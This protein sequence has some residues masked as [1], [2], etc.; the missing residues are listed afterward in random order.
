ML[1]P[2][3]KLIIIAMFFNFLLKPLFAEE[4]LKVGI[5]SLP[6]SRGNPYKTTTGLPSL[7]THAALFEGLTRV[8]QKA[9]PIPILAERWEYENQFSWL[10]FLRKDVYFSNNEPFNAEAV[11]YS[12]NLL[13]SDEG[14]TWNVTRELDGISSIEVVD[15]YTVRVKTVLPDILLPHKVASLKIIPPNYW[16]EVGAEGFASAPVGTGPYMVESWGVSRVLFKRFENAWRKSQIKKIELV[17]APDAVSRIQGFLSERFHIAVQLG[18]DEVEMIEDSGHLV[19]RGF[20]PSMQVLAFITEKKSPL[21]DVRVRKALNFAV[22]RKVMVSKLLNNKVQMATQTTPSFA[23]GWDP[24]IEELPYDIE[25]A[26]QLLSDAGYPDGFEF[27]AEILLSAASYSSQVY[28][29]VAVDLA[30]IGVIVSITRIPAS[31]YARG[32][33]QGQWKGEAIGIDYGV[34]PTLDSLTPLVRHSCLWPKPW[35]C[36][37]SI[38]PLIEKAQSAFDLELRK[39]LTQ[40]VMRHQLELAPA[41]LLYETARFDAINKNVGGYYIELGHIDYDKLSFKE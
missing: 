15:D 20:D 8:S 9:K 12:F 3:K 25:K 34:N 10:F 41:I 21:Q 13:Q 26:K 17:T 19:S 18:P 36:E 24:T 33:Y 37:S 39:K 29:Q 2:N 22:N 4:V 30:K 11:V 35:F 32:V 28:Q 16:K 1:I 27:T 7:Y 14:K 5:T 38:L 23:F 6:T 40:D 31:Q